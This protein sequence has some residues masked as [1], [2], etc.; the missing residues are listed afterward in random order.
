LKFWNG[1]RLWRAR[2]AELRVAICWT[3]EK[4]RVKAVFDFH[5]DARFTGCDCHTDPDHI[6]AAGFLIEDLDRFTTFKERNVYSHGSSLGESSAHV[7]GVR[8]DSLK[9]I[10]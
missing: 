6:A 7:S 4:E 5:G 1:K 2:W 3:E 9:V 10:R 8:A